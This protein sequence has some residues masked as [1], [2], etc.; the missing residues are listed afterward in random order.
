M[1]SQT[2][3]LGI[4]PGLSGAVAAIHPDGR[5]E[6]FDVPTVKAKR[7]QD[8][9]VPEMVKLLAPYPTGKATLE[10]SA[11]TGRTQKEDTTQTS[12]RQGFK[13]GYGRGLWVGIL[14]THG[15][16]C[17]T[18][19]AAVWKREFGLI[20]RDKRASREQACAL[21][22]AV[23]AVLARRRPDFSEALLLA[24]WGRRKHRP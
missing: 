12:A 8:Y 23:R 6:L 16:A 19:L 17:E 3:Y 15:I 5:V 20:G 14:A 7:G 11:V 10:M 1:G 21:F 2:I 13:I 18:V 9:I 22:P 24:E 4:D